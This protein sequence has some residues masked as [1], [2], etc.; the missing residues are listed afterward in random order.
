[1]FKSDKLPKYALRKL[2]VG[3][4]SVMIGMTFFSFGNPNFAK[5]ATEEDQPV[6]EEASPTSGSANNSAS[7]VE[8]SANGST[9]IQG[10]QSTQSTAAS[11]ASAVATSAASAVSSSVSTTQ[12]LTIP[13]SAENPATPAN[14]SANTKATSAAASINSNFLTESKVTEQTPTLNNPGQTG[15]IDWDP[16]FLGDPTFTDNKYAGGGL[17]INGSNLF[18]KISDV[19]PI[20]MDQLPTG[21]SVQLTWDKDYSNSLSDGKYIYAVMNGKVLHNGTEN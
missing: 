11:S 10:D 1:M 8:N 16:G 15:I 20:H 14:S 4:A 17:Y 5:A 21:Y 3:V 12:T 6:V 19:V 18:P 9:A 7:S 13:A 2:T